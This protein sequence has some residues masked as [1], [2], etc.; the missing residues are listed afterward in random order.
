MRRLVNLLLSSKTPSGRRIRWAVLLFSVVSMTS[1]LAV[2]VEVDWIMYRDPVLRKPPTVVRFTPG[3]IP[4]WIQALESPQRDLK[5]RAAEAILVAHQKGLS[6]LELTIEPLMKLFGETGQDRTVRLTA[7]QTLVQL[8]ARQAD[9]LFFESLGGNDLDLAAVIEPAL[10]R[11]QHRPTAEVWLDRLGRNEPLRQLRVLAIRG[12]AEMR[13]SESL[14]RLLQLTQDRRAAPSLR[15]E[16][17]KALGS[18]QNSGLEQPVSDLI[19]DKT[20]KS[21]VDRLVAAKMLESHRGK[22]AET[23]M[24]ELA[25]DPEPSV[26]A[27]AI[28]QLLHIDPELVMPLAGQTINSPDANVRRLVAESLVAKPSIEKITLLSPLLDDADPELRRYVCDSLVQLASEESFHET[29]IAQG[30]EILNL[31]SW[32]GQEQAML[33]LVSLDDKA[34]VDRL[35]VLLDAERW[36]IHVTASWGLCRLKVPAT[37]EA[38]FEVFR[39]KTDLWLNGGERQEE[40]YMQLAHLAQAIGR[41]K[42]APADEVLRKYIPKGSGLHPTSRSA[43]I[44]AVGQLYEDQL[45][46][47]LASQFRSRLIDRDPVRPEAPSVRRMSAI[48]LARM[49]SKAY[50]GDLW[51]MYD[52]EGQP[53]GMRTACEWALE[54]LTGED[55]P[56]FKRIVRW[57]R[58]WFLTPVQEPNLDEK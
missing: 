26:Q 43:G 18:L 52:L 46:E 16:A 34:I 5:R 15:L 38:I 48:A 51:E 29:I 39:R 27:I 23:L 31:E 3:L 33:L 55:V 6:G 53:L 24:A 40:V 44:W 30:R 47:Q 35:L 14:P 45:D 32:R 42:Y 56:D 54:Q 2:A 20:P 25:L 37:V 22:E 49:G 41:M 4:L 9:R 13:V 1:Q 28:S 8:D 10:A 36:E 19:Q 50:L 12:L 21:V 17:A 7:A 58:D 57:E 11:W